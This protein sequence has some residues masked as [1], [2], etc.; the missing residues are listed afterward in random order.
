MA[1]LFSILRTERAESNFR[2]QQYIPALKDCQD[3]T[4][5]CPKYAHAWVVRAKV[6][7]ALGKV[8]D[9][10][11]ELDK[12][13][14]LVGTE[15]AL[16]E[17][18]YQNIDFQLRAEK[19]EGDL[20]S[21]QN[22]LERGT[23]NRLSQSSNTKSD[24]PKL[25]IS[26]H[27]IELPKHSVLKSLDKRSETPTPA[28][29]YLTES[30]LSRNE[31]NTSSTIDM[32]VEEDSPSSCENSS[33]H[34]SD[35]EPQRNGTEVPSHHRRDSS[36]SSFSRKDSVPS[37]RDDGTTRDRRERRDRGDKDRRRREDRDRKGPSGSENPDKKDRCD[38]YRRSFNESNRHK[39]SMDDHDRRRRYGRSGNS[40]RNLVSTNDE[41]NHDDKKD[42]RRVGER[43]RSDD[44][45]VSQRNNRPEVAQRR[46]SRTSDASRRS[47][48]RND[49]ERDE[50]GRA[51]HSSRRSS[52]HLE[53]TS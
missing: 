52:F 50:S 36:R 31:L 49:P 38:G 23:C 22:E 39:S 12:I 18:C 11:K 24:D 21:F 13:R 9:A 19:V 29:E 6:L 34:Q 20:T 4:S 33:L 26:N 37:T 44:G 47:F 8:I 45:G 35:R 14:R 27:S 7:V 16:V 28:D 15:N 2:G 25:T 32:A 43:R 53:S 48:S 42:S 41:S 17:E 30:T 3:V 5:I 40:S 1:P 51:K 10:K 46:C